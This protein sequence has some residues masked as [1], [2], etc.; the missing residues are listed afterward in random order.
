MLFVYSAALVQTP[1]WLASSEHIEGGEEKV[2]DMT[3]ELMSLSCRTVVQNNSKGHQGS[4]KGIY[5]QD[6]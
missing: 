6:A 1:L 4:G 3:D 2:V 5:Y